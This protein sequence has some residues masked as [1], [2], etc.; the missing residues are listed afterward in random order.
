MDQVQEQH[1]KVSKT[2]RYFTYGEFSEKTKY[3]WFALHGYGMLATSMIKRFRVFNPEEHYVVAPEGLSRFYW[4]GPRK[5]VAT[6]MTS[7]DR[8]NEI[9]DYVAYLDQ[10]YE[11]ITKDKDLS[12][13]KINAMAFSQGTATLARWMSNG[14]SKADN[15]IFWAGHML[16]HDA[17]L[18]VTVPILNQSKVL[19]VTGNQD[20]W[21]SMEKIEEYKKKI[22]EAGVNYEFILFDG[23]HRVDEPTLVEVAKIL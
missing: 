6:W 4:H 3:L 11:L 2:A 19:Y 1:L 21:M 16:P 18:S 7:E 13:C 14:K 8:L 23:T 22:E 15:L 17:D 20:E 10:V 5:P 9:A 12:N